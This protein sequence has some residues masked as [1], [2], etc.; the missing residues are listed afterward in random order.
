[1]TKDRLIHIIE[2]LENQNPI[3]RDFRIGGP[4]TTSG[5]YR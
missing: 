5:Q 4:K 1:M 2:G 3:Y